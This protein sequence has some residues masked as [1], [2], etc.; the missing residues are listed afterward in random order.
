[1][2][3]GSPP[4]RRIDPGTGKGAPKGLGSLINLVDSH[5]CRRDWNLAG[6]R[7]ADS[8]WPP[9][10]HHVQF[11]GAGSGSKTKVK[12]KEVEIGMVRSIM[13]SEDQSYRSGGCTIEKRGQRALPRP[14]AA[15]GWFARDLR[16]RG[17]R[18]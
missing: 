16:S 7:Y 2:R 12:F 13:L 15:S 8:T 4:L 17:Y 6:S 18:N 1:M 3:R 14:I 11:G 10:H 5:R 9:N